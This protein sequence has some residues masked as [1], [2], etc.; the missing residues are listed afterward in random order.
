LSQPIAISEPVQGSVTLTFDRA[1]RGNALSADFVEALIGAFGRAAAD[2]AVHTV[3]LRANGRHF[4]TGFDLADL[5][6]E[7]DATLLWRFVR[8]ET[9]LDMVWRAPVR[10]VAIGQGGIVGAGA[11]LFAVCD[12][13]LLAPGAKLRFPGA[14]FGIVLGTR[15]LARRVGE[16]LALR[17]VSEGSTVDADEAT[18]AGLATAILAVG[19]A[20]AHPDALAPVAVDRRTWAALREVLAGSDADADLAALVRTAGRPGLKARIEAYRER[21]LRDRR[22]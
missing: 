3:V 4:C 12:V 5:E 6:A 16:P 14:G 21:Q 11:D 8:I 20:P 15:R 17:W 9:L 22:R 10:T 13:R 18:R 19:P 1:D 2:P 7:T